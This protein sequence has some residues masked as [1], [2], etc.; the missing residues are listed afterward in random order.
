HRVDGLRQVQH[1]IR[2]RPPGRGRWRGP[3]RFIQVGQDGRQPVLLSV[4]VLE[5]GH[6]R[7]MPQQPDQPR[8]MAS[9]TRARKRYPACTNL[10]Y[11]A[12]PKQTTIV[13]RWMTRIRPNAGV[14]RSSRVS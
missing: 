12:M 14:A 10:V 13:A 3:L 5:D 4:E 8:S 9:A 6:A 1:D 11:G 7:T 2:D